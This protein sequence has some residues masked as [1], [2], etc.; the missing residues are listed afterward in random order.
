MAKQPARNQKAPDDGTL[1]EWIAAATRDPVVSTA[2]LYGSRSRG[3]ERPDSDY[4]LAV[5]VDGDEMPSEAVL[6]PAL[7][8]G[9]HGVAVLRRDIF[10]TKAGIMHSFESE[11]AR[12]TVVSG[13]AP[14]PKERIGMDVDPEARSRQYAAMASHMWTPCIAM[15]LHNLHTHWT[16]G[17]TP[18]T[19]GK[20]CADAAEKAAKLLCLKLNVPFA[21]SHDLEE[22]S[23]H[24]PDG[25]RRRIGDLDGNGRRLHVLDYSGD[26][27]D[28]DPGDVARRLAGLLDL[29]SDFP[30]IGEIALPPGRGAEVEHAINTASRILS[31]EGVT[32]GEVV[33]AEMADV[34]AAYERAASAWS[35]DLSRRR[36]A[37]KTRGGVAPVR[38]GR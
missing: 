29:L 34:V 8:A 35:R 2:Y 7:N 13:T 28:E 10:A 1:D 18:R 15:E 22:A 23:R 27:R 5:L 14:C 4:D 25:I 30:R 36:E 33:V 16:A 12:G 37:Q 31:A 9:R 32:G 20:H 21:H 19:I 26:A 6:R 17:I 11:V 3:T 24:L 38:G